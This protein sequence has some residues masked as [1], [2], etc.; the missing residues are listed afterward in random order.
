L[1]FTAPAN[2]ARLTG[3][4]SISLDAVLE[5]PVTAFTLLVDGEAQDDFDRLLTRMQFDTTQITGGSHQLT[6]TATTASGLTYSDSVAVE[7]ANPTHRLVSAQQAQ[8]SW[9]RGEEILVDLKYTESNL[10]LLAD[11]SALDSAYGK[12]D[13]KVQDL[14]AGQYQIRYRISANDSASVGKYEVPVTAR[15]ADGRSL[16]SFI[17]V[18]YVGAPKLPLVVAAPKALFVDQ[19]PVIASAVNAPRVEALKLPDALV[20]GAGGKMTV[21]WSAPA[22]NPT[23]RIIVRS[24]QLSGAWVIPLDEP[25]TSGSVDIPIDLASNASRTT[26]STLP[27]SV[28]AVGVRNNAAEGLENDMAVIL[29]SLFGTSVILN[30]SGKTDLDLSVTTPDGSV[31]D[32][33]HPSAQGGKIDLDSNAACSSSFAPAEAIVWKPGKEVNGHYQVKVSRFDSCGQEGDLNYTVTVIACGKV[34]TTPKVFAANATE[35]QILQPFDVDCTHR[36][37]GKVTYAKEGLNKNENVPAIRVPVR[38]LGTADATP[39]ETITDA[40]G[41]YALP[42]LPK[43]AT[44]PRIQVDAAW[45]KTGETTPFIKVLRRSGTQVNQATIDV[46]TLTNEYNVNIEQAAGAGAFNILDILRQAYTWTG[47][48]FNTAQANLVIP[49]NARWERRSGTA[50]GASYNEC[51]SQ[52]DPAGCVFQ[53]EGR[54]TNPDENDDSVIAHEYVHQLARCFKIDNTP[55]GDH[56]FDARVVPTLAWSEGLASAIGQTILGNPMFATMGRSSRGSVDLEMTLMDETNGAAT[57]TNP[58]NSM[59]GRLNE[60]LVAAVLWDLMD[61]ANGFDPANPSAASTDSDADTI[62]DGKQAV[63]DTLAGFLRSGVY[64]DRGVTGHD[65]VEF[66]DGWRCYSN[67]SAP[68][69]SRTYSDTPLKNLLGTRGFKYDFP[70]LLTAC[71]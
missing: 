13:V 69:Q 64:V 52:N 3:L 68:Q 48:T 34:T 44:T 35:D 61:P 43:A 21:T 66:L 18:N 5:E 28:S 16:D 55:G 67:R 27:L 8:R 12:S 56:N 29:N 25:S 65:L 63:L 11:F 46:T 71:E 19:A 26:A 60:F 38:I 39:P 4:A 32:Y 22:D 2:G 47:T 15:A 17:T 7:V 9:G 40:E 37:R 70:A 57:G 10:T 41:N 24:P 51:R 36:M 31:I 20:E 14:G 49:T 1:R 54:T 42:F 62:A 58:V 30:W 45:V 59:T 50:D 6:V 33:E 23:D 53:F